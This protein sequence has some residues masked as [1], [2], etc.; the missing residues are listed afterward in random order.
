MKKPP[1]HRLAP[2]LAPGV[3]P[4]RP[5]AAS[6]RAKRS[7]FSLLE[8]V[9]A[10]AILTG[11]IAVL[12]ELARLGLRH[13]AAA[14]DMTRAQLLCKSKMAEITSGIEPPVAVQNAPFDEEY[15]ADDV[16]WLYSVELQ[17]IDQ[18]GLVAVRVTVAQDVPTGRRPV[19][20]C[21]TQW[22]PDPNW[23]YSEE[24]TTT[25]NTEES[26]STTTQ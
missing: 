8:V 14:R 17:Q 18:D 7:G 25:E 21:L 13:A 5:P 15:L 2:A 11:A 19:A 1:R 22:I 20:C 6:G 23:E 10:L 9:L 24:T 16:R 4:Q 26:S 12:G 3:F